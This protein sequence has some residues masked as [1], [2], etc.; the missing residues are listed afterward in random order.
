MKVVEFK[1]ASPELKAEVVMADIRRYLPST[2][3]ELWLKRNGKEVVMAKKASKKKKTGGKKTKK[4]EKKTTKSKTL[5]VLPTPPLG[6]SAMQ[7]K[8]L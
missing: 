6:P 2:R 3:L 1:Q 8:T 7:E 5:R 4:K